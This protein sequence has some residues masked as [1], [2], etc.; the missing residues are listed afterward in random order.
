MS[1]PQNV[2]IQATAES[3]IPLL[4]P[5]KF[6]IAGA[7]KLEIG[8]NELDIPAQVS[9]PNDTNL[10]VGTEVFFLRE[11]QIPQPDGSLKPMWII[12]ESG[13]VNSDGFIRTSSPPWKG[14]KLSGNYA[15]VVPKFEYFTASMVENLW[16][17][18]GSFVMSIV[19]SVAAAAGIVL[20]DKQEITET[21]SGGFLK[22]TYETIYIPKGGLPPYKTSLGVSL[23]LAQLTSPSA[24][25][26][27]SPDFEVPSLAPSIKS[28]EVGYDEEGVFVK[29]TGTNFKLIQTQPSPTKPKTDEIYVNFNYQ[30]YSQVSENFKLQPST[31]A[32]LQEIIA[33]VPN[34][35]PVSDRLSV[36]LVR[37]ISNDDNTVDVYNSQTTPIQVP[38]FERMLTADPFLGAV[39]V[40]NTHNAKEIANRDGS[41]NLLLARIPLKDKNTNAALN[42]RYIATAEDRAY[43]PLETG[44][45]VAIIDPVG[46]RQ[47]DADASTK[48]ID[49]IKINGTGDREMMPSSIVIGDSNKYAYISDRQNGSIY[50]IDID[51][52]SKTYHRHVKT[53]SIP[54]VKHI[55]R[56]TVNSNGKY[57]FATGVSSENSP[58]GVIAII[59]I[60][61]G[62]SKIHTVRKTI[63]TKIGLKDIIATDNSN[64]M[65]FT[66]A[67]KC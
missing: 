22:K 28:T 3:E 51:P 25:F 35:M 58:A 23:N 40:L 21:S 10:A 47:L 49:F 37:V 20:F 5:D 9:I 67:Q 42:P 39:N 27:V 64:V 4:I 46:L 26:T 63:K 24:T 19:G 50:V 33:R 53:I 54:Q 60:D 15:V 55:E 7:F 44:N 34:F 57:L 18:A 38:Y 65:L 6:K 45:G 52:S 8:N 36:D 48:E 13:R 59:D 2:L 17:K 43:V 41:A 62:S 30:K 61:L 1:E 56:I 16:V 11:S 32:G 31:Q 66:N 14:I 12:E 29:I